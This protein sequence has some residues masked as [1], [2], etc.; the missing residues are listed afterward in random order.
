MKNTFVRKG[1]DSL[2]INYSDDLIT[3]G[4]DNDIIDGGDGNDTLVVN[5]LSTN[6]IVLYVDTCFCT[7]SIKDIDCGRH[8]C[9]FNY[10]NR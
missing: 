5:G 7:L 8:T 9:D 10:V 3:G 1:L 2:S 6:Y 4:S